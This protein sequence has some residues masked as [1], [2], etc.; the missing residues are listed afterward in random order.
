MINLTNR[1]KDFVKFTRND[2]IVGWILKKKTDLE[3]FGEVLGDQVSFCLQNKMFKSSSSC[4]C[5]KLPVAGAQGA[6]PFCWGRC[7]CLGS[8][9]HQT[10]LKEPEGRGSGWETQSTE[11]QWGSDYRRS[12][13][14]L[15]RV[16]TEGWWEGGFRVMVGLR[17][18]L[19]K[20]FR[21][22]TAFPVVQ[23][24]LL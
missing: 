18:Y 1:F 23:Y 11:G 5:P 17:R 12:R 14:V 8:R 21:L 4:L 19:I 20:E 13:L 15:E 10:I 7:T 16:R 2:L 9:P 22:P 24:G 3:I 6:E